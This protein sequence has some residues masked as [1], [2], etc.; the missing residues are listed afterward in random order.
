[1]IELE[2]IWR[3][4]YEGN[5]YLRNATNELL[6]ERL[7]VIS[8]NLWSTGQH[9]EVTHPRQA[10]VR[11]SLLKLA[12][13]VM[14][15]K[16]ERGLPT[17]K[18]LDEK[19][20]RD[21]GVGSYVPPVLRS[22]FVGGP[23]GFAKYGKRDHIRA[24]FE[25]GAFRIAAASS[26]LDPSL[27]SAQADQELEHSVV[28]P[29]EQILMKLVG[30]DCAGNEIEIPHTP[31]ELIRYM[32]V[33]NFYVWCCGLSYDAR[34]F[35]DFQA[36]AVV[37]IRDIAAF[38]AR[39]ISAVEADRPDLESQHGP[40]VYYDPYTVRREQ[41]KPMYSKNL[42]YLYQNEYRFIWTLPPEATGPSPFF[43]ELGPLT[44]IAEFYELA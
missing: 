12:H 34:M 39:F 13:H 20:L 24:S 25:R 15:E 1:M 5:R 36:E 33:P 26:Y 14:L 43:V 2:S 11:R 6:D 30:Q 42:R 35:H 21:T 19:N 40:C 8:A 3:G 32:R 23:S 18:T 17:P 41:L 31:L 10:T 44:D 22:P 9:G 27:N 37:M 38:T 29:N 28:T 16:L 7:K 4:E